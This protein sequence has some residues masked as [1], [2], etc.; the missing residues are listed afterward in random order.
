M[1]VA[2]ALAEQGRSEY[3]KLRER[4]TALVKELAEVRAE[5]HV[6]EDLSAVVGVDLTKPTS[7][8]EL[9]SIAR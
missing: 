2:L 8:P 5:Y 7:Q 3:A 1:N 6:L 4:E 9:L